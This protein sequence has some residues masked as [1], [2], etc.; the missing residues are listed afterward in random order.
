MGG[1][2]MTGGLEGHR[3]PEDPHLRQGLALEPHHHDE[4]TRVMK[5][6]EQGADASH[7]Y[8]HPLLSAEPLE[9]ILGVEALGVV[10]EHDPL[11]RQ[12][13]LAHDLVEELGKDASCPYPLAAV[14]LGPGRDASGV[15]VDRHLYQGLVLVH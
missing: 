3:P 12:I 8:D 10:I 11:H 9:G 5:D 15:S 1:D 7:Q 2:P 4:N 14:V 6:E 13:P